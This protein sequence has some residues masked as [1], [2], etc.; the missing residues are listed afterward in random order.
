M[1]VKRERCKLCNQI[2]PRP[3][4]PNKYKLRQTIGSLLGLKPSGYNCDNEAFYDLDSTQGLM[5]I[6]KKLKEKNGMSKDEV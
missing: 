2:L 6:I 3:K 5:D 4:R 1:S